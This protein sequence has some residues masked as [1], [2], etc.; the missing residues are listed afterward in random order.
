MPESVSAQNPKLDLIPEPD[1]LNGTTAKRMK[2]GADE[3][4]CTYIGGGNHQEDHGWVQSKNPVPRDKLCYYFEISLDNIMRDYVTIGFAHKIDSK[5]NRQ[6]GLTPE[7]IGY[8]IGNQRL[9]QNEK[10]VES[11]DTSLENEI[12][13]YLWISLFFCVRFVNLFEYFRPTKALLRLWYYFG[14]KHCIFY[15]EW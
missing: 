9:L 6:L 7:S 12:G 13:M 8:D 2:V 4:T 10:N 11:M 14:V 15:R 1:W 5:S 3:E